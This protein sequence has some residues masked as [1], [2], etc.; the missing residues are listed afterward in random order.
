MNSSRDS[1]RYILGFLLGDLQ[2]AFWN[3]LL[4]NNR[5]AAPIIPSR[6]KI[7]DASPAHAESLAAAV[8]EAHLDW[9]AALALI[10]PGSYEA[11]GSMGP[12]SH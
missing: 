1:L 9:A 7:S 4:T 2:L 3:E 6:H 11:G 12:P 10:F 5:D 8:P